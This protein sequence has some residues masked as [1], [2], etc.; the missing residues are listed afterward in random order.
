MSVEFGVM[1]S[2]VVDG[3]AD[4]K[5]SGSVLKPSGYDIEELVASFV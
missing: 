3:V 4:C 1:L 5:A 2:C